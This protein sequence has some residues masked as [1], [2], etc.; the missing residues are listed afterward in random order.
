VTGTYRQPW[1]GLNLTGM[2]DAVLPKFDTF[3]LADTLSKTLKLVDT[4][5][6]AETFRLADT[7]KLVDTVKLAETFRLADTV[8]LVDTVKLADL[9]GRPSAIGVR[10]HPQQVHRPGGHFQ[11][12]EHVDSLERDR[13]VHMEEI[14]GQHGRGLGA[15]EL[16]P[17]RV[18]VPDRRWRDARPLQD[19]ADRGGSD[20]VTEFEQLALDSL[21]SPA[22]ILP[23]HALDQHGHRVIEGW[24]PETVGIRPLLGDQATMPPQDRARRDQPMPPQHPRQPADQRGEHRSIRP[25]QAR[26]RV[27]SAQH[28]DF[29][30]QHQQFDVLGR[31]RATKQYQQVQ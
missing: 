13:A 26:P 30:S 7:V 3:K 18:G 6:L 22:D 11:Y 12:E 28:G 17:G 5:K 24:T 14:A 20:T 23:G 19:A 8:K 29:M 15:Q 9:L 2:F 16:P 10:S 21:V 31:R 27:G 25:V 1:N 4:M